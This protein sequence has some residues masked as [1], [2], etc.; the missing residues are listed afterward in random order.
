VR[1]I[2]CASIT[3]AVARLCKEANY[4]LGEDVERALREGLTAEESPL[5]NRT[6]TGK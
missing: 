6:A 2:T 3:E 1:E 4:Y 5:I